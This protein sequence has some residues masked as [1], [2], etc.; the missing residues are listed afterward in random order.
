MNTS[1]N[2]LAMKVGQ[3]EEENKKLKDELMLRERRQFSTPY[4]E[5]SEVHDKDIHL[6]MDNK[7]VKPTLEVTCNKIDKSLVEV[8]FELV[9]NMQ[10][11]HNCHTPNRW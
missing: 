5:S 6:R 11:E 10:G 2:N 7:L 3:M 9:N 4:E 1:V 8:N